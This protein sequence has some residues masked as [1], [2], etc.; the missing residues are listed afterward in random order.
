MPAFRNPQCL[1]SGQFTFLCLE[2]DHYTFPIWTYFLLFNHIEPYG[3]GLSRTGR[4][5]ILRRIDCLEKIQTRRACPAPTRFRSTTKNLRFTVGEGKGNMRFRVRSLQTRG[6]PELRCCILLGRHGLGRSWD[7]ALFLFEHISWETGSFGPMR[8]RMNPPLKG[9][10]SLCFT[11]LNL[12]LLRV[13]P[14]REN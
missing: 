7:S 8:V 9:K 2:K 6:F 5:T 10:G 3:M 13:R 12:I 11:I 4:G 14:S 1:P